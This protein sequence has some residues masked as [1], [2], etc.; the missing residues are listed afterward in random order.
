MK[1]LFA[2]DG[3]WYLHRVYYT[4]NPVHR[5]PA[6]ALVYSF[7]SMVLKDALAVQATNLLV[8]FDG[9]KV[10]RYELYPKYKANRSEKGSE[11]KVREG[12]KDVYAYLPSLLSSLSELGIPWTQPNVYEADD[13]LCSAVNKYGSQCFIYCGTKDKDAYQYLNSNCSLYDSSHKVNGEFRPLIIDQEKAEKAKGVK[14]QQMVAYQT[15]IGDSIDNVPKIITPLKAKQLLND[16]PTISKALRSKEWSYLSTR[17][18]D[19]KLN[20][21]LVKLSTDV[22][23]PELDSLVIPKKELDDEYRKHLPKHYF[24]YIEFRWPRS[25]GLF[26]RL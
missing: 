26:S 6:S 25:K 4:I 13:V 14:V 21:K 2:V 22:P 7:I 12:F 9:P 8:A 5:D 19:M 18:E 1:K 17:R 16:Y 24:N 20:A 11:L 10:F 3:N 15:L 23:L